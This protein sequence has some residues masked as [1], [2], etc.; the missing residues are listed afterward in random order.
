MLTRKLDHTHAHTVSNTS[1]TIRAG[2]TIQPRYQG[3]RVRINEHQLCFFSVL[4]SPFLRFKVPGGGI[5]LV[6]LKSYGSPPIDYTEL[7]RKV[8]VGRDCGVTIEPFCSYCA[9]KKWF[10]VPSRLQSMEEN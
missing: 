9:E 2:K 6:E 5:W 10:K 1:R 7:E 4:E 8:L 3:T